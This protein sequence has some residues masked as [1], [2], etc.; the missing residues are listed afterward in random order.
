MKNAWKKSIRW[1]ACLLFA[2]GTIIHS[3]AFAAPSIRIDMDANTAGYQDSILVNP[4]GSFTTNV[5]VVLNSAGD[6]LSSFGFSLWWDANELSAPAVSDITTYALTGDWTDLS[7][8]S[9]QSPYIYNFEQ[10]NQFSHSQG[11]LSAIVASITWTAPNV[12][13]DGSIDVTPGAYSQ[14]DVSYDKD[15]NPVTPTFTGGRVNIAPE[16]VSAVLLL[17]GGAT[18]AVRRYLRKRET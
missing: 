9:I 12:L 10:L 18:I 11:P 13:T 8:F 4:N 2:I 1:Q 7:Y 6:S 17:A 5:E 16:P 14:L 15:L 3:I